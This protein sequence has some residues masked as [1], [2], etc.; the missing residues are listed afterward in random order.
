MKKIMSGLLLLAL[1]VTLSGTSLAVKKKTYKGVKPAFPKSGATIGKTVKNQP[2]VKPA[3]P[4]G[5]KMAF[6]VEG[7]YGGGGAIVELGL[8]K[9]MAGFKYGAG[10]GF[11]LGNGYSVVALEPAKLLFG[12]SDLACGV[13]LTYAM[14]SA[15]VD[16]PIIK[17]T[18]KSL[19]GVS[20]FVGKQ[21]GPVV[22]KLGFDTALGLKAT[23]SYYF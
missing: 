9:R 20:A 18:N 3:A 4:T 17:I 10:V 14:Y 16:L 5:D 1:A 12:S 6:L 19:F 13:G 23:A 11:G 7:G 2:A 21:F 8:E 22:G 15:L